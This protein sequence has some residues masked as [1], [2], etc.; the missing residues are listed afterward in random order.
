MVYHRV[1]EWFGW[2]GALKPS[3]PIPLISFSALAGAPSTIPD[4]SKSCPSQPGTLPGSPAS[5][6]QFGVLV[7]PD[8]SILGIQRL[9]PW[10]AWSR[11]FGGGFGV[12]CGVNSAELKTPADGTGHV[13]I[14]FSFSSPW[15]S[16]FSTWFP[17]LTMW[18]LSLSWISSRNGVILRSL[19]V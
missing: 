5:P 4:Y 9:F 15:Q 19:K 17:V 1:M 2:E 11:S 3:H 12:G 16:T 18:E 10:A 6:Y 7:L 13:S 8:Y 14:H